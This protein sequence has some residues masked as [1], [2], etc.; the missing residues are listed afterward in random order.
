M[1]C[2][3]CIFPI[4]DVMSGLPVREAELL[5]YNNNVICM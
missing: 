4:L 3:F 2:I 1:K 5:A